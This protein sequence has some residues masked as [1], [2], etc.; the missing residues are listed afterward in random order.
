MALSTHAGL[1]TSVYSA[2]PGSKSEEALHLLASQTATPA[3][4]GRRV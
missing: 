3:E 4:A 1:K 2:E